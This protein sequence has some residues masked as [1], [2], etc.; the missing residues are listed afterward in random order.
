VEPKYGEQTLEHLAED[1]GIDYGTLKSYRTTYRAWRNQP[2]RPK[3]FSVAK[4]L[5]SHPQRGQIVQANP[6][7]TLKE[8]E[9]IIRSGRV[10]KK[11]GAAKSRK[12]STYMDRE[13]IFIELS[14]FLAEDSKLTGMILELADGG[15]N[16]DDIAE[17][18]GSVS[19]RVHTL[20]DAIFNITQSNKEVAQLEA[21]EDEDEHEEEEV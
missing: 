20:L 14:K 5:N 1:G 7:I 9:E 12:H 10:E 6:N 19:L 8:A 16:M 18:L 11:K 3:S 4:A 21:D 15:A 13:R 17:A 2:V